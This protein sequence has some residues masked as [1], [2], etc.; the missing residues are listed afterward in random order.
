MI[1]YSCVFSVREYVLSGSFF[2]NNL[3]IMPW[4]NPP[5][6]FLDQGKVQSPSWT[7]GYSLRGA[8]A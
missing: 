5:L 7:G 2:H 8:M 4:T 6:T 1:F 3:A